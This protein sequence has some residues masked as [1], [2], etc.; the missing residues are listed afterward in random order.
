M[1]YFCNFG[2]IFQLCVAFVSFPRSKWTPVV[3]LWLFRVKRSW[4][5]NFY[6][7]LVIF[8]G[9]RPIWTWSGVHNGGRGVRYGVQMFYAHQMCFRNTKGVLWTP[10]VSVVAWDKN[11]I[12]RVFYFFYQL[13]QRKNIWKLFFYTITTGT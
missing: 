8:M 12:F 4:F 9:F 2:W 5:S 3:F 7:Y 1:D 10:S 11:W 13:W 6:I